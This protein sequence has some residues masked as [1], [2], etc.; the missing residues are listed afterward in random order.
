[1]KFKIK[2]T[3]EV[4]HFTKDGEQYHDFYVKDPKENEALF[5]ER[6][7]NNLNE[8]MGQL[9]SENILGFAFKGYLQEHFAI[10]DGKPYVFDFEQPRENPFKDEAQEK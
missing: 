10:K 5:L 6:V 2:K 1:M 7:R 3:L 9:G 8:T 4:I